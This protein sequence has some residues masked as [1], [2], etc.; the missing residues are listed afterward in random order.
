MG[1]LRG[2]KNSTSH[3]HH[4]TIRHHTIS[5]LHG[6]LALGYGCLLFVM[7]H[8]WT[9][10]CSQHC[11]VCLVILLTMHNTGLGGWCNLMG[12][13]YVSGRNPP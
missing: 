11:N 12:G 9:Y 8:G 13:P 6:R 2:C 4:D 7:P 3:H 10:T 1:I 5:M